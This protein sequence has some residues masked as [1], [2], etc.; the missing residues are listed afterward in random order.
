MK[1]LFKG[2]VGRANENKKNKESSVTPEVEAQISSQRAASIETRNRNKNYKNGSNL[3]KAKNKKSPEVPIKA[4]NEKL[5]L[6]KVAELSTFSK[7]P[8]E[9]SL[10]PARTKNMKN[11]GDILAAKKKLTKSHLKSD[12]KKIL[13]AEVVDLQTL[14]KGTNKASIEKRNKKSVLVKINGKCN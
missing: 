12:E 3:T 10:I 9:I 8:K 5:L 6:T 2:R 1:Y 7:S 14:P 4:D 13:S 11:G